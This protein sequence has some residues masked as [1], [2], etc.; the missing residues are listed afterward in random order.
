MNFIGNDKK[1]L[2]RMGEWSELLNQL[3]RHMTDEEKKSL[4]IDPGKLSSFFIFSLLINIS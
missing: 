1:F 2:L 4:I 3:T